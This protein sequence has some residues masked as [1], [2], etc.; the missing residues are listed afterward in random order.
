MR[1]EIQIRQEVN[2]LRE[3]LKD[4]L[5]ADEYLEIGIKLETL[6]WVL[7]APKAIKPL[8]LSKKG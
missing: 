2:K 6:E 3:R 7:N 4:G 8:H 5:G 1:S